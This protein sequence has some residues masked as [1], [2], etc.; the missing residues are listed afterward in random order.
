[1]L[2]PGDSEVVLKAAAS[3]A[4]A[5]KVVAIAAYGSKV[6]GY[7]R[8]D[9]DFD[10]IVVLDKLRPRAKYIYGSIDGR[11][12]SALLVD[13]G[14]FVK[15]ATK[16]SLG[17]FVS[18]R[19][20]N[21][22][23]PLHGSEFLKKAELSLKRRVVL[24]A[25]EELL[26]RYDDFA[27]QMLVPPS[28]FLFEKL[29]KRAFVYPPVI[30]SYSRT[31]SG[32]QKE[33]NLVSTLKGFE[34]V[35]G[36]LVEE[37]LMKREGGY[38]VLT[39][40]S[41]KIIKAPLFSEPLRVAERGV[42]QYI[43]HGFAGMVGANTAFKE[44][45]SKISRSRGVERLPSE[46]ENPKGLIRL[47]HG[48]L[49]FSSDWIREAIAELGIGSPY[50]YKTENMGDFFS[51]AILY[52]IQYPGG[53]TKVVAKKFQDFWSFKWVVANMMTVT[54][55][56]F[57]SKP[58]LRLSREYRGTLAVRKAG[59]LAPRILLVAP[60][61]RVV[62]KEFVDGENLEPITR[63]AMKGNPSAAEK[64]RRFARVLGSIH[65]TNFCLGDTKPSNVLINAAGVNIVDLEQAEEGGEQPWDIVEYLYYSAITAESPE[66]AVNLV[67]LFRDGYCETGPRENMFSASA[68]KYVLPF[69]ILVQP[70]VAIAIRKELEA[71]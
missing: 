57:E 33:E 11:Q 7:S 64:V 34:I 24:E 50:Q 22:Y 59:A 25:V 63:L 49:V 36:D 42:R 54:A 70:P 27:Q 28:Y 65:A 41:A 16:A 30:Y 15:D 35:I 45:T 43:A 19:L 5:R 1:M 37:G 46:L 66:A 55:K 3:V 29:K 60:D 48:R 38:C 31:Y 20:L 71:S 56:Q 67:R 9:S 10:L 39:A 52:T 21:T 40:D 51:S 6:A 2:G 44:L 8:P 17:E 53:E 26:D 68:S 14:S 47:P 58:L 62:V 4:K 12:F 61:D 23:Q 13:E 69:Q 32:P 18:G